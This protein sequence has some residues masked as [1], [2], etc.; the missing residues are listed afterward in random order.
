LFEFNEN[1]DLIKAGLMARP[2]H[3]E[4]CTRPLEAPKDAEFGE[5]SFVSIML[6][7]RKMKS[8]WYRRINAIQVPVT[9]EYERFPIR[10]IINTKAMPIQTSPL[11]WGL[12]VPEASSKPVRAMKLSVDSTMKAHGNMDMQKLYS[13]ALSIFRRR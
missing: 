12:M 7:L 4:N 11:A 10:T 8:A 5:Y 13:L 9:H 2:K 1:T 6:R 3:I